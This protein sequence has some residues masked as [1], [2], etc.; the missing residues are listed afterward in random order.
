MFYLDALRTYLCNY[1]SITLSSFELV[2]DLVKFQQISKNDILLNEGD[3]AKNIYF[4]GSG[5]VRAYSSDQEGHTYNKNIFL[6]GKM[7]GSMVSALLQ[8]PSS[9]TLQALDESILLSLN[10]TKFK[11]FILEKD[12]LKNYYIAY[13]E[14]EWVMDKEQREVSL[15]MESASVRYEKFM[16][17]NPGID[18][19]ISL[20][21][22]ASHL[23]ITPTQLI[24][25]RKD[26]K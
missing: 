2:K 14:K 6:A 22:I 9:F 21:H 13:L 8:K 16:E 12:D 20:H 5:V 23:G 25:I 3:V 17:E 18:R 7:V 26:L 15:V 11:Q 10:F 1:S 24:R 4:L 19:K